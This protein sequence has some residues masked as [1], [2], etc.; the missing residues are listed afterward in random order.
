MELH[1]FLPY[2]LSV[3]SNKIS[4]GIAKFYRDQHGITIPEWRVLAILSATNHQTAKEL[5][6]HSQM[7]KVKISRTMKLLETKKLI[8]ERTCSKDARARRYN[9]TINGRQ[10]INEVKPKALAYENALLSSLSKEQIKAFQ[11]C[12]E[13]LNQQA[14][15][16]TKEN[17]DF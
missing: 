9:L 17:Q 12:I 8:S 7:D 1:N 2:Q 11:S 5:T 15:K 6:E 4:K 10:L 3:L 13:T 14:E 16:I